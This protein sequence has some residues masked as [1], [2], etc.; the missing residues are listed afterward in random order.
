M[1]NGELIPHTVRQASL[2]L[3]FRQLSISIKLI[4]INNQ[5]RINTAHCAA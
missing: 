4:E 2:L 3:T 5:R 1:T